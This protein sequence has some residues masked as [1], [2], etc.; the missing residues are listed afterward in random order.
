MM[1]LLSPWVRGLLADHRGHVTVS[2]LYTH[3]EFGEWRQ[4]QECQIS[5]SASRNILAESPD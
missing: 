3:L 1:D 4:W 5:D 2:I